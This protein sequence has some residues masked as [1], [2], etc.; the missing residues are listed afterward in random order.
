MKSIHI[1]NQQYFGDFSLLSE[2]DMH[3]QFPIQT[4]ESLWK[5]FIKPNDV[6]LDIGAYVGLISLHFGVLRSKVHAFEGS[7]RNY[8]RLRKIID[9]FSAKLDITI[10]EVALSNHFEKGKFRFNDC[11][12]REHPA[13]EI[14]YVEYDE[15]SKQNKLPDPKFVKMDIEGM[16]T[17]ALKSMTRLIREVRPI[18]QIE[19]HKDLP[20]KYE[21]YPGHVSPSE[22]G[23]DMENFEKLGYLIFDK[24]KKRIK[25]KDMA[26]LENYF[27]IPKKLL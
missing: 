4:Y 8:F 17:I 27:F 25:S 23:F 20:F 9:S 5:T 22:G 24:N 14:E 7:P 21:G 16:E 13:Q 19:C 26:C 15:Y 12:D 2:R 11:I 3:T 1:F 6:V 18:W 10:H